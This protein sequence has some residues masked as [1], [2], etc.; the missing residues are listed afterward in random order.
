MTSCGTSQVVVHTDSMSNEGTVLET[1]LLSGLDRW[2]ERRVSGVTAQG[3]I[4]TSFEGAAGSAPPN[5][6]LRERRNTRR[7]D[8]AEPWAT[9]RPP[10]PTTGLGGR[11]VA[12]SESDDGSDGGSLE[13]GAEPAADGEGSGVVWVLGSVS[14]SDKTTDRRTDV[15]GK[16][17]G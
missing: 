2:I 6:G 5:Q 9:S 7:E 3:T 16:E 14:V 13:G 12:V 17:Q 1:V 4:E 10:L 8:R 11:E 15:S